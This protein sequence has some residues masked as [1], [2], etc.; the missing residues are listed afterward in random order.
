MSSSDR[1][2]QTAT[3]L[4]MVGDDSAQRNFRERKERQAK[5]NEIDLVNRNDDV[6]K[7]KRLIEA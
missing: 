2:A 6:G 5:Q 1:F 7:L 3:D 4:A